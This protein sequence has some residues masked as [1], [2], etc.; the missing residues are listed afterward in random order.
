MDT[1]H[2]SQNQLLTSCINNRKTAIILKKKIDWKKINISHIRCFGNFTSIN[3][4]KKQ[5][6]KLDYIQI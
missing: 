5:K 2:Y 6:N 1:I 4:M 3:I